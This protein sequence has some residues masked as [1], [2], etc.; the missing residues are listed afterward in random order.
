MT[1]EITIKD[2]N[3]KIIGQWY[4]SHPYPAKTLV[5]SLEPP[6]ITLTD[7]ASNTYYRQTSGG[8]NET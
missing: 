4:T 8:S 6:S 3:G 5:V 7:D 1:I 2:D